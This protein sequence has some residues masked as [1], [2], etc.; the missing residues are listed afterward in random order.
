MDVGPP[1]ARHFGLRAHLEK[2]EA[3]SLLLVGVPV[4]FGSRCFTSTAASGPVGPSMSAA[5]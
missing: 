1:R 5:F 2:T 3:R 4:A